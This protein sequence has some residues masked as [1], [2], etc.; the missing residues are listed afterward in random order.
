AQ[1][2]SYALESSPKI[3]MLT[4]WNEFTF[5]KHINAGIGQIISGMY[6]IIKDDGVLIDNTALPFHEFWVV[7][8]FANYNAAPCWEPYR[9]ESRSCE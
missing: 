8:Q 7:D 6:T 1:Q 4:G 3:V 9:S 5:G 2:W